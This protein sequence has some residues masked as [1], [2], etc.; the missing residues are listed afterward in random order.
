MWGCYKNIILHKYFWQ[1]II[2]KIDEKYWHNFK[3]INKC[4]YKLI[5]NLCHNDTMYNLAINNRIESILLRI[6]KGED[7][8]HEGFKGACRV[9]NIDIVNIMLNNGYQKYNLGL[10]I[11]SKYGHLKLVKYMIE[12]GASHFDWALCKCGRV[13]NIKKVGFFRRI[14][15]I[16]DK[17][18]DR[19]KIFK[20]L[21]KNGATNFEDALIYACVKGNNEIVEYIVDNQFIY[22][23]LGD[24]VG[25]SGNINLIKF[26]LDNFTVDSY[27]K[28]L[29]H[30]CASC[31]Q[32]FE[33]EHKDLIDQLINK[34]A[35]INSA[36]GGA[37]GG[38]ELLRKD[39]SNHHSQ[40]ELINY[41]AGK[42]IQDFFG[43][44]VCSCKAG[45]LYILKY[46]Q[47]L[48]KIDLKM[49]CTQ[50]V[51]D[52][53]CYSGNLEMIN[54]FIDIVNNPYSFDW[55]KGL[56]ISAKF[57]HYDLVLK[58]LSK[59]ADNLNQALAKACQYE[60]L[61]IWQLLIDY[62]ADYC[63]YCVNRRHT[64]Q[65]NFWEDDFDFQD[66]F[67]VKN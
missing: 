28:C 29:T 59:G 58:M 13:D 61:N 15:N 25:R 38:L 11:S 44:I 48:F 32:I 52:T 54:Y 67:Y 56:K 39:K 49:F 14:L 27:T 43:G 8:F 10:S 1:Y 21:V 18:S 22:I 26:I 40:I 55:N 37:C 7:D 46:I 33:Q 34:G 16:F 65:N 5:L 64:K 9:G 2:D 31:C 4:F 20:L 66:I 53:I 17:S 51:F 63:H 57:G 35:N 62:G 19:L 24:Y 50:T 23:D 41:L 12:R 42:N 45:N 30:F 3:K 47:N 60:H 36:L 6:R